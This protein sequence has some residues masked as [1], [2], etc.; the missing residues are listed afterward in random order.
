MGPQEYKL[1]NLSTQKLSAGILAY[2]LRLAACTPALSREEGQ[3]EPGKKNI[4]ERIMDLEMLL[5]TP[6]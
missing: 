6:S 1:I 5:F 4:V 2:Q 3:Q